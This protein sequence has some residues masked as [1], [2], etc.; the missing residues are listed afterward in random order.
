MVVVFSPRRCPAAVGGDP[1]NPPFFLFICDAK[2]H[3][4]NTTTVVSHT[5]LHRNVTGGGDGGLQAG[6]RGSG[7]LGKNR[8]KKE[9]PEESLRAG[10]KFP[11]GI[12]TRH[13]VT[14]SPPFPVKHKNILFCRKIQNSLPLP[15]F[16]PPNLLPL[17][18]FLFQQS[19]AH[20]LW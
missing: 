19:G 4:M 6:S 13:S 16:S 14:F 3:N 9:S 15:L 1:P 2:R 10:N 8:R 5:R 20:C 12:F 7:S 11:K 17:P 18:F